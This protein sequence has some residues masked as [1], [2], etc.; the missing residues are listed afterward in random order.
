MNTRISPERAA[1]NQSF[2]RRLNDKIQRLPE[3][4]TVITPAG[5]WLCECADL[6]CRESILL[7]IGEYETVRQTP[8]RFAVAPSYLH[9]VPE[10]ERVVAK[11]D[12]YWIVE[13]LGVG[14]KIA[15][16]ESTKTGIADGEAA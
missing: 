1:Q 8:T 9:V 5:E 6:D 2:F 14:A 11:T 15:I 13:K 3:S 10:V 7:T 4:A 12:R 16:D